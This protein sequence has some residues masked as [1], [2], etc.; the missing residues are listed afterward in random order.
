MSSFFRKLY[1]NAYFEKVKASLNFDDTTPVLKTRTIKDAVEDA[2]RAEAGEPTIIVPSKSPSPIV[3]DLGDA[4][5]YAVSA[6]GGFYAGFTPYIF[7]ADDPELAAEQH[8]LA[9]EGGAFWDGNKID[10]EPPKAVVCECGSEKVGSPR[11]S[12]WC[13]KYKEEL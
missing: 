9:T 3:D 10:E 8:R 7:D 6:S 5:R 4:L 11:H 2:L 13:M 12:S 1:G